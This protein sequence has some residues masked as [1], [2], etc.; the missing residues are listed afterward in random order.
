MTINTSDN[1]NV[2][3]AILQTLK[4]FTTMRT[5]RI[6]VAVMAI[7]FSTA[8]FNSVS[9]QNIRRDNGARHNSHQPA[10][11][12][13][14]NSAPAHHSGNKAYNYGHHNNGP[15][16]HN[17]AHHNHYVVNHHDA[18]FHGHSYAHYDHMH[19]A[20]IHHMHHGYVPVVG[21][22][23]DYLPSDYVVINVDGIRLYR[24]LG[25]IFRP[26]SIGGVIHFVI[27]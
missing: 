13:G 25:H 19:H 6:M 21:H 4:T 7:A 18:H 27:E 24:A 3:E 15:V 12:G 10:H 8:A 23:V 9:A 26:I 17:D 2:L 22:I 16:H 20:T 1:I 5:L 11:A 14:H